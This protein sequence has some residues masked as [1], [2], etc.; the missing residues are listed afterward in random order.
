[1]LGG[2]LAPIDWR[3]VFLVS[4]PLG[5][6]GTIWAYRV[7]R[8][9]ERAAPRADRLDR[10]TSPSPLG[11]ILVMIGITYGI[12]PYHGHDMGWTSPVVLAELASG[13]V[14]LVVFG[15]VESQGRRPD[16]P[17]GAV[18]DPRLHRRHAASFLAAVAR[19][20]LCSC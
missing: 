6:F 3:L 14:L 9:R 10:A 7:L 4:V 15:I 1:M 13:V 12:E 5:L 20:G 16:V 11:L 19:G 18:P 2:V 8:E 17:P